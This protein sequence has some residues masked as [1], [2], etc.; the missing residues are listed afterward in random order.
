MSGVT[1]GMLHRKLVSFFIII[2]ELNNVT[3][4]GNFR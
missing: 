2:C 1:T 3:E 4:N